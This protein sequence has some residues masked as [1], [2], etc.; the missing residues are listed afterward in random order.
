MRNRPSRRIGRFGRKR[1]APTGDKIL[2]E[3]AELANWTLNAMPLVAI[4]EA[5]T[6]LTRHR[7][8]PN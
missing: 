4:P 1:C 7:G 8:E 3:F 5:S 2:R 6:P